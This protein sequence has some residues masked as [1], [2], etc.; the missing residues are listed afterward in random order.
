MRTFYLLAIQNRYMSIK[1]VAGDMCNTGVNRVESS[2]T[3]Q[4]EIK[5]KSV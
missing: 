1:H 3:K 4:N 2:M 5:P